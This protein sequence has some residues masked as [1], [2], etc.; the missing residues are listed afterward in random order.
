MT[1]MT[2]EAQMPAKPGWYAKLDQIVAELEALP[3]PSVD[4]STL[5]FL[6][7]VGPRRTQQIME[8]CVTERVGT[9]SLADR[10]LLCR[11]LRQLALGEAGFH[12]QRRRRRVA[13]AI[14]E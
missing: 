13:A 10:N 7:G 9:S 6:P 2:L 8:G 3:G 4:R 12:E 11:H 14:E 5:G 1:M